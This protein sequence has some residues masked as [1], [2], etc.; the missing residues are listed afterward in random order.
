M[1][2]ESLVGRLLKF[3]INNND[4]F[5]LRDMSAREKFLRRR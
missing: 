2:S 5:V 4:E 3:R 1:S